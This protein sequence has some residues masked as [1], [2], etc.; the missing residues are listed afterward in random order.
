[1]VL[2]ACILTTACGGGGE[3]SSQ[4]P[5]LSVPG[6]LTVN[7][8]GVPSGA[9]VNIVV[10][11]PSGFSQTISQTTTLT[12]IAPGAY[13]FQAP[14]VMPA[15]NSTLTV[16]TFSSNPVTVGSGAT[17][18]STIAYGSLALSWQAIGPKAIHIRNGIPAAG[19]IAAIAVNNADPT[20][21]YVGCGGFAGPPTSTGVYQTT[22]GGKT[23]NALSN[24]LTDPAV[25]ALWLDQNNPNILVAGTQ[26]VGM[27][28]STD[29]GAS[30]QV[31][32]NLGLTTALLQVGTSLYAGTAQGIAVSQD[33]GATW[34]LIEPTQVAVG[35]LSASGTYIYAG[36]D[37]GHVMVQSS[38]NGTWLTTQPLTNVVT[39]SISADPANPLHALAVEQGYY[40]IPDL[41]ETQNGG[42]SWTPISPTVLNVAIQDVAFDPSDATGNTVYAGAD[43]WFGV[44]HD[45]GNTWTQ[46]EAPN[47]NSPGAWWDERILLPRFAGVPG[48]VAVGA[49]QGIYLSGDGGNS[50]QSLNGNLTTSIS[51]HAAV[52]GQTIVLAMQDLGPVSSFDG[53]STWDSAQSNNPAALEGGTTLIN[54][55]NASYAYV[56]NNAGFQFSSDGGLN[57]QVSQTLTSA[58]F[59]GGNGNSQIVAVDPQ[60]SANVYAAAWNGSGISEGIYQSSNYGLSW[61][62]LS[63][64]IHQ[65]VLIAFDPTS[66]QNIF[67]GQ[68]DGDLQVSHDG[69]K[70]WT[71]TMLG[72]VS[73]GNW[74]IAVAINPSLPNRV[75][76]GMSGPPQ[77]S[78]GVLRSIDGGRS[79]IAANTGLGNP[80]NPQPWPDYI[81]TL[82]YDPAGSGLLVAARWDGIYMSSDDGNTWVSGR[83]NTLPN[84]FTSAMWANGSLYATTFGEG[85]VQLSV[86]VQVQ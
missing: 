66:N 80:L 62:R 21:I 2:I 72:N 24:G 71:A 54:P 38:P 34:S 85:V 46:L 7:V 15:S 73:T 17:A 29:G 55:G 79:F 23:W 63:W 12:S 40:S 28:R 78:G 36:L 1:M 8:T 20:T 9:T 30:W 18:T 39:N 50:W 65:P 35:S 81:F 19:Q 27:F 52:N 86:V 37:D 75:T 47:S 26:A 41:Y 53:G 59:P 57:Y 45:S 3:S 31:A 10:T 82:A 51:Y 61:S 42:T 11:G 77:Q 22:D 25:T 60:A 56:Y 5:P 43:V 69:G 32:S 48:Q 4:P 64:P 49:D 84:A 6:S 44:S 74:P 58:G 16:P 14:M 70:T 68:A 76:V 67:V 33:E 13:S 83:G